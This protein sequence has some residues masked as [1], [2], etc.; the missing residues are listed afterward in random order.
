MEKARKQRK[1]RSQGKGGIEK[2]SPKSLENNPDLGKAK[3]KERW[4]N[5]GQEEQRKEFNMRREYNAKLF[6]RT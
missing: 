1:G 2:S 6:I 5:Q 4:K 3:K